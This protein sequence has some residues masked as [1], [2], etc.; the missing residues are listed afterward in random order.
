[1][2]IVL[3]N[4]F[5]KNTEINTNNINHNEFKINKNTNRRQDCKRSSAIVVQAIGMPK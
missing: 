3:Y 4:S 2:T 1:M 5:A